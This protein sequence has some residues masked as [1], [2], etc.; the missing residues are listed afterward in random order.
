MSPNVSGGNPAPPPR[1]RNRTK[2]IPTHLDPAISDSVKKW[3]AED[4]VLLMGAVSHIGDLRIVHAMSTGLSKKFSLHEVEERWYDLMY[5]DTINKQVKKRIEVMNKD[6]IKEIQSKIPFSV[7][8]EDIIGRISSTTKVNLGTFEDL[9]HQHP[10]IFH[11][12][13]TP[14]VLLDFWTSLNK[15]GYL[16]DQRKSY[17][18]DDVN[19]GIGT[20]KLFDISQLRDD[21]D[22]ALQ[23]Q[24]S[25]IIKNINATKRIFQDWEK[26][27]TE[28][29][30]EYHKFDNK[31]FDLKGIQ[32]L[33]KGKF[34][35]FM[36][37]DDKIVVGRQTLNHHV[38]VNLAL[39]GPAGRISR[40]N[41]II[42][43]DNKNNEWFIQNV[44][45]RT[46]FVDSKPLVC[47]EF[48]RLL[49]GSDIQIAYISLFFITGP[50]LEQELNI[51]LSDSENKIVP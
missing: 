45:S 16:E 21:S 9:I 31:M 28:I 39:E 1:K 24:A 27:K 23:T 8:E 36:I 7:K 17:Y 42:K 48:A 5:N 41:A 29:I 40:C 26:V 3:T 46:I 35:Y 20:E 22:S 15:V 33:L 10:N 18:N 44:G 30:D 14:K 12:A 4:D 51:R 19:G 38:D 13:R 49:D 34:N 25:G 50:S 6:V 11:V 43:K 32:A 47:N 37:K 2:E